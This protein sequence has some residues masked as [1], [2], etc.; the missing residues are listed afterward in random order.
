ME[1]IIAR[2]GAEI[3]L[4]RWGENLARCVVFDISH[5]QETYGEGTV[6]L[7]HQRCGDSAPYPCVI[8]VAGAQVRWEIT[9]TDVALPGRG[10]AELQYIFGDGKVKSETWHTRTRQAL[11]NT[12]PVPDD[13]QRSWV[14]QVLE[15]EQAV[16]DAEQRVQELAGQTAEYAGQVQE[17]KTAAE[18]AQEAARQSEEASAGYE[19]AA[20]E[21]A[22]KAGEAAAYA[23]EEVARLAEHESGRI[24]ALEQRADGL[25]KAVGSTTGSLSER[26]DGHDEALDGLDDR[27]ETLEQQMADLLYEPISITSFGHDAGIK[28]RGVVIANVS[29]SWKTNKIPA[30]LMLDGEELDASLNGIALTGLSISKD[31]NKTWTLKATDERDSTASKTASIV[32]LNCVYYGMA[33]QPQTIDSAFVRS[34]GTKTAPTSTRARSITLA[35]DGSYVWY[36]LPAEL[37]KCTFTSGGFPAGIELADTISFTNVLGY[38]EPYYVYRSN[39]CITDTVT[40][41]VS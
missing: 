37:G 39:Q 3:E 6:Q 40:I 28:E 17:A 1:Q 14:D 16:Y 31:D 9:E 15:Q 20:A 8:Q 4:G 10:S 12:G 35:G 27:T 38:T 24:D 13:P 18:L 11:S 30:V 33:A 19:A 2:S 22:R 29:L 7:L 41:G 23:E 26:L 21:S 36:C 25:E 5:W 34:L 32:F